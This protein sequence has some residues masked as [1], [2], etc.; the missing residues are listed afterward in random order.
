MLVIG[1]LMPTGCAER[2]PAPTL[3]P[4]QVQSDS[5]RFFENMKQEE[6]ERG[7][8]SETKEAGD[9]GY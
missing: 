1:G 9:T 5:D 6:R 2:K 3:S 4:R 8:A 7:A